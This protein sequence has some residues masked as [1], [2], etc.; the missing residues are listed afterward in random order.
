VIF[1]A[2]CCYPLRSSR[3]DDGIMAAAE[4]Q[5]GIRSQAYGTRWR[6][7]VYL[8][9]N[10]MLLWER[11]PGDQAPGIAEGATRSET[12]RQKDRGSS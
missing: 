6:A 9:L 4:E 2:S 10:I 8:R 3:H 12:L 1:L 7:G 11:I 5:T